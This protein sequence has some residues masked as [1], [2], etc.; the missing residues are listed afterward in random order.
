MSL[1][2]ITEN[3]QPPFCKFITYDRSVSIPECGFKFLGSCNGLF[4]FRAKPHQ[5][6]IWNPSSNGNLKTIPDVWQLGCLSIFGFGYDERNDDYKVVYA[7]NADNGDENVVLVSSFKNGTWKRIERE[8]SS[9]FVNPIIA[10][11]TDY[12]Y[13]QYVDAIRSLLLIVR[14]SGAWEN[15]P[16]G[17]S[18]GIV[19]P[20]IGIHVNGTLNWSSSTMVT[21]NDWESKIVCFNLTTNTAAILSGPKPERCGNIS[22]CELKGFLL[23][24]FF[25]IE[26]RSIHVDANVG[27]NNPDA[28]PL[29]GVFPSTQPETINQNIIVVEAL[30]RRVVDFLDF[31]SARVTHD[32]FLVDS[33]E[34]Q[35]NVVGSKILQSHFRDLK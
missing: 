10:V 19:Y 25:H 9:G 4:C 24:S 6:I 12:C 11:F 22:I 1:F 33:S 16:H 5:I 27:V 18:T 26:K 14:K 28:K 34:T 23:A 35:K 30:G 31:P 3:K 13:S 2:S 15:T 21:R 20:N 8:L 29:W 32:D 7:Y 17:L